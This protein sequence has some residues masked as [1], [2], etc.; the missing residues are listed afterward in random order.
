MRIGFKISKIQTSEIY[1]FLSE[2]C[3]YASGTDFKS[4]L[5]VSAHSFLDRRPHIRKKVMSDSLQTQMLPTLLPETHIFSFT[6]MTYLKRFTG[7]KSLNKK[8]CPAGLYSRIIPSPPAS[9]LIQKTAKLSSFDQSYL[10]IPHFTKWMR[11]RV[12]YNFKNSW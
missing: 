7:I 1:I 3:W 11:F 8:Q 4:V 10:D 9:L 5:V 12:L 2:H 6:I